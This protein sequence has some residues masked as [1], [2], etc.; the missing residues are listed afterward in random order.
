MLI[1]CGT[2]TVKDCEPDWAKAADAVN[3]KGNN[4]TYFEIRT[5]DMVRGLSKFESKKIVLDKNLRSEKSAYP[6]D[7]NSCA[8]KSGIPTS[9][10]LAVDSC[11]VW[12][13]GQTPFAVEGGFPR[14]QKLGQVFCAANL[15]EAKR[16]RKPELT[17]LMQVRST[18]F[19]PADSL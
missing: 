11:F 7:V 6:A 16:K 17:H 15:S 19:G 2:V 1:L 5:I 9:S 4:K 3:A 13:D 10:F 8:A 18:R 12:S 14:Q